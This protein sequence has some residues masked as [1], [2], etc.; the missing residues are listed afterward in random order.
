MISQNTLCKI[1]FNHFVRESIHM[2]LLQYST[3]QEA[4][5]ICITHDIF[6]FNAVVLDFE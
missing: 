4:R 3:R 5:N 1:T 6:L 2:L